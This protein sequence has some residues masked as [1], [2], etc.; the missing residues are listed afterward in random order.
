MLEV[1]YHISKEVDILGAQLP[2]VDLF[3][4]GFLSIVFSLVHQGDALV[5]VCGSKFKLNYVIH[6]MMK[7][8]MHYAWCTSGYMHGTVLIFKL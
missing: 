2:G 4:R 7:L 8:S 3:L 1:V 5:R 6:A